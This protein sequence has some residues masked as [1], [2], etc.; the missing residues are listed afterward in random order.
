MGGVAQES[1]GYLTS[2]SSTRPAHQ[3]L[4]PADVLQLDLRVLQLLGQSRLDA[5]GLQTSGFAFLQLI[6][7]VERVG[8]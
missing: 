4:Q 5:L 3:A 2:F 7:D 1:A 6:G 8:E